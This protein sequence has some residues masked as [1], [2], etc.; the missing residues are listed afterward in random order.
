[1]VGLALMVGVVASQR[2]QRLQQLLAHAVG[3]AVDDEQVGG[4]GVEGRLDDLG[5][6][7]AQLGACRV[8]APGL[9]AVGRLDDAGKH[10]PVEAV[11][12]LEALAGR[13]PR[14][15]QAGD[16]SLGELGEVLGQVVGQG[17]VTTQVTQSLCVVAVEY[18]PDGRGV[19]GVFL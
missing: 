6:Q 2:A 14:D 4:E 5:A 15:E 18:H 10:E 12:H 9:V 3:V 8:Q 1:M 19:H 7:V 13:E 16:R 17:E 11:G